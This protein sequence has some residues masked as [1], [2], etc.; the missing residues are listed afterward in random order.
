[1]TT[2]QNLNGVNVEQL[3]QTINLIKDDPSLASFQFRARNQWLNGGHNR[4]TIQGFYGAGQEDTTRTQA[5]TMDNDEPT[6]L[7]GNDQAPN[8]TE[9]L[10]HAL[11]GCLT[12]SLVYHAAARGIQLEE[13]E[14]RLEGNLD[15]RGF[16]GMSDQV[17][18]GYDQIRVAFKI[19]G[20]ATPEQLQELCELA[21]QRSPVFD[22]VSNPVPI[23]VTVEKAET[24][25]KQTSA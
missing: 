23:A 10:F 1:M 8:P 22:M 11:A 18:N 20:D 5:F 6:L 17:R 2:Q 14:S 24:K 12:T 25:R 15:L 4:T 3:M 9:A 19:K 16:L 7:L 21:K 13:V